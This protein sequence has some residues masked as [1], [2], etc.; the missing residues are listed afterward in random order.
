LVAIE[1]RGVQ[2]VEVGGRILEALVEAAEPMM[3]RDL[4][5]RAQLSAG[6]A[7]VYLTS[8]KKL[9][10]VEQDR[11]NGLYCVGPFATRLAMARLHSDALLQRAADAAADLSADLGATVT[12]T[13]WGSGAPTVLLVRDGP[14][15]LTVN[16]RP[17][18][19]YGVT[20]TATGRLYAAFRS[21]GDLQARVSQEIESGSRTA[22]QKK[23]LRA[24]LKDEIASARAL[25]Y[26]VAAGVPLPGINS[27]AAPVLDAAREIQ[28]AL[29]VFGRAAS[30]NVGAESRAVRTLKAKVLAIGEAIKEGQRDAVAS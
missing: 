15:E 20:T 25:G 5:E 3:L 29:T 9:G 17:G 18:R 21:A 22:E 2:S 16:M 1:S 28:L 24:E 19:V 14:E 11:G 27:V 26:A 12:L 13:V 23:I 4:A 30:L 7:H 10:L 6:Q 8:L